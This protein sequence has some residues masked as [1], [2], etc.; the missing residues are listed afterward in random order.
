VGKKVTVF[1]GVDN[2]SGG[3]SFEWGANK[4]L[5]ESN[6]EETDDKPVVHIIGDG[7][8]WAKESNGSVKI[9]GNGLQTMVK[10][11]GAGGWKINGPEEIS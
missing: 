4:K 6:S 2:I 9:T 1:G 8:G 5:D 7:N 10:I 11:S 3:L